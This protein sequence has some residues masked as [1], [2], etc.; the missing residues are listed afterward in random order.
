MN[1]EKIPPACS[2]SVSS[3]FSL[4]VLFF[5]FLSIILSFF[6]LAFC[7][8]YF[9]YSPKKGYIAAVGNLKFR[10]I[11]NFNFLKY[12]FMEIPFSIACQLLWAF[13]LIDIGSEQVNLIFILYQNFIYPVVTV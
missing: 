11:S 7:L 8:F 4:P 2:F 1:Y 12:I 3:V 10:K 6:A 13:V 5:G 9:F